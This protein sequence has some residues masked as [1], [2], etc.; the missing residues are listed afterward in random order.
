MPLPETQPNVEVLRPIRRSVLILGLR[1]FLVLF[2]VDTLFAILLLA[3][4]IGFVP[5]DWIAGYASFLWIVYTVKFIFLTYLI[6]KLV[7]EWVG[8]LYYVANGHL[9]RQRGVLNTTETVF[10]LSDID[11]AVMSQSWLGRMWNFGSVTVEF[12]VAFR[13]ESVY[14][15]A[16]NDPQKYEDLFMQF[17]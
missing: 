7:V 17:V 9:I 5:A 13:K 12:S 16:I 6:I 10:Q 15:H 1:I 11:S 14:L 8:T 3:S 2:V 4:V